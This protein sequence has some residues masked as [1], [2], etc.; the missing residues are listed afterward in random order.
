MK[1]ILLAL[2]MVCLVGCSQENGYQY[3]IGCSNKESNEVILG[4]H[5]YI[6]YEDMTQ[7]I[8]FDDLRKVFIDENRY[9]L[10]TEAEIDFFLNMVKESKNKPCKLKQFYRFNINS[11]GGLDS[12]SCVLCKKGFFRA[13]DNVRC[14]T[15]NIQSVSC[16]HKGEKIRK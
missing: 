12:F 9:R 4:N 8:Q 5:Y 2:M 13:A 15:H 16:C 3:T 10:A 1:L 14:I 7:L 11:T 6:Q